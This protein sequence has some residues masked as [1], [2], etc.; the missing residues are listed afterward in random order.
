VVEPQTAEM[1]RISMAKELR[2]DLEQMMRAQ[3][4]SMLSEL[5]ERLDRALT[6]GN[7]SVNLGP[8]SVGS[9]TNLDKSTGR[10]DSRD[11]KGTGRTN[12]RENVIQRSAPKEKPAAGDNGYLS[13]LPAQ[14][15][16][17]P[18][19][20]RDMY[21]PVATVEDD[22]DHAEHLQ[23]AADLARF[24]FN[25]GILLL[26]LISAGADAMEVDSQARSDNTNFAGWYKFV[27]A[28]LCVGF[29]AEL[30]SRVRYK[31]KLFFTTCLHWHYFQIIL[32]VVQS[33]EMILIMREWWLGIQ[34]PEGTRQW[35]RFVSMV[36][37]LRVFNVL[38][39]LD[40]TAEL[41]L[42]LAS[43]HGSMYS[44][45]WSA[46]FMLIPMFIISM[47]M[48]QVVADFRI[49]SGTDFH[50]M[51]NLMFYYGTLDKSMFALFWSISGGLSWS[52]AMIP[53]V[54]HGF[55]WP[56]AL[57]VMYVA[58]MVFAVLNVLT[59]VFVN[60]ATSAASSEKEK[61]VLSTL[62]KIFDDI[63]ND[64]SG[65][66]NLEEFMKLMD[67]KDIGVCLQSLDI[68][69]SHANHLFQMIDAD[70]SGTVEI[71]EF[72]SGCDRLQGTL[73]ALDFA[74]FKVD[75][76]HAIARMD[77]FIGKMEDYMNRMDPY[78]TG[79]LGSS[80]FGKAGDS[81][82][83]PKSLIQCFMPGSNW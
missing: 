68:P 4:N 5:E 69:P 15:N 34:F 28:T 11:R 27:Q 46:L 55:V 66:L 21:A 9:A 29:A 76:D 39:H 2:R 56:T 78:Q 79:G 81:P 70:G 82:N 83:Q 30:W 48:T 58:S 53:L 1:S 80:D 64:K 13:L 71:H 26:L 45:L 22:T 36:R 44:L 32:L 35:F 19:S 51:D 63:D 62:E 73:K 72:L 20:A 59:G 40:F 52:E 33:W 12:S 60:S 16:D 18:Q 54:N 31:G 61:R 25:S 6:E 75:N 42:L 38:D 37:V 17:R 10:T 74:T 43:M 49:N 47:I 23:A 67:H 14:S 50:E 41:H 8:G 65:C 3:M 24:R 77:S 7:L 57:F